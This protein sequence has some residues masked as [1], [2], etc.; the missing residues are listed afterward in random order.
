MRRKPSCLLKMRPQPARAQQP[1]SRGLARA[2]GLTGLVAVA[3]IP[4]FACSTSSRIQPALSGFPAAGRPVASAGHDPELWSS[5][6]RIDFQRQVEIV[7][8]NLMKSLPPVSGPG[9]VL[10]L[11]AHVADPGGDNALLLTEGV[12]AAAPEHPFLYSV[13]PVGPAAVAGLLPGD[14][15]L[16]FAGVSI[17]RAG[18]LESVPSGLDPDSPLTVQV[19]RDGRELAFLLPKRYRQRG[20]ELFVVDQDRIK[21]FTTH[22]GISVTTA[23]LEFLQSP[24]ELAVVLGHE[25]AHVVR[26]HLSG[27]YLGVGYT[28]PFSRDV[29]REA[30][31]VGLEL[32]YNA[33]Y[34]P[35]VGVDIWERFASDLS[36]AFSSEFFATHPT[37]AERIT[38]ARNVAERLLASGPCPPRLTRIRGPRPPCGMQGETARPSP[39]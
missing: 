3:L 37:S 8:H 36:G 21:A 27:S 19:L 5:R 31:R 35:R 12:G 39:G 26:G 20:L 38:L 7:A 11:G 16:A 22:K 9:S 33:G 29:E 4:G 24:D 25:I 13:D 6:R 23:M 18:D 32:A 2:G 28:L 34:D 14:Q 10:Y 15:L 30:D 1:L 17:R